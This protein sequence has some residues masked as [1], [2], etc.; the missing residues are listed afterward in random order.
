MIRIDAHLHLWQL[1]GAVPRWL[2]PYRTDLYRSFTEDDVKPELRRAGVSAAV[3]VQ[4]DDTVADTN[5]LL[6]VASRTPWIIGVVGWLP[7]DRPRDVAR[8]LGSAPG[9]VG[10]RQLIHDDPRPGMLVSRAVTDSARLIAGIGLP[11]DVPDAWPRDLADV[12]TL[13]DA[14]PDLV[15]VVDHLGKPPRGGEFDSWARVL[16]EVAQRDNVVAKISGLGEPR[17]I[18]PA[19]QVALGAFG[20]ERLM[21]GGDWPMMAGNVGYTETFNAVAAVVDSLSDL[22]RSAIWHRT[23][24][25]IYGLPAA[26]PLALG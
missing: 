14:V 8:R 26:D 19:I 21:Y 24:Q 17:G 1:D 3:L 22:E 23:A 16:R 25:R 18:E 11:L 5:H 9:I 15:L 4:S 6:M 2:R 13:A 12:V 20:A 10:V 7:I